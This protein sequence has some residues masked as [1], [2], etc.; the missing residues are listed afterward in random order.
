MT[1]KDKYITLVAIALVIVLGC[2]ALHRNWLFPRYYSPEIESV[3]KLADKNRK[4]FEK[5]LKHY[6][7]TPADSLKLRAAEF[8]KMN[9]QT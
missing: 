3:L 1:K 7:K 5:V 6:G 8:L 9:M 2:F 4:E